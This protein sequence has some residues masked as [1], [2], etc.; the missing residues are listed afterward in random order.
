[1]KVIIAGSRHIDNI[2][3]LELAIQ[4]SGFDITEVVSGGARGVDQLGE[5][6][7]KDHNIPIKKF[8]AEWDKYGKKAGPMRNKLMAEYGEALIAI[9]DGGKGTK[10]MI[11]NATKQGLQIYIY[12]IRG[13]NG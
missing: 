3:F 10:N 2:H 7:A 8:S 4:K 13:K 9:Y 12:Y 1:M 6:W 11:E 5:R